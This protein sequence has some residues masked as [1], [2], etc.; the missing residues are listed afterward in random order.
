MLWWSRPSRV[1]KR[2][3]HEIGLAT[4]QAPGAAATCPGHGLTGNAT[5][6]ESN[7]TSH[8]GVWDETCT[9]CLHRVTRRHAGSGSIPLGL[10][11][12]HSSSLGPKKHSSTASLNHTLPVGSAHILFPYGKKCLPKLSPMLLPGC[13]TAVGALTFTATVH[14]GLVQFNSHYLYLFNSKTIYTRQHAPC[15]PR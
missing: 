13:L 7:H 14:L 5:S 4:S 2:S 9:T 3:R 15:R 8:G 10:Y 12:A 11:K 1:V 6:P